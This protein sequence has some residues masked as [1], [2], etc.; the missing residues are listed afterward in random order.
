MD[1]QRIGLLGWSH[2]GGSVLATIAAAPKGNMGYAAAVAFY[3]DC[4]S[5]S[6]ALQKFR[7]YAPLLLL[8]GE[9]DDWTPAAPCKVL[10]AAVAARGEPMQI[11][12]YP[13]TFH[14]FDS[15]A[16]TGKRVRTEVPNGVHPGRGVTTA[17]N[18]EA[19]EDAKKRVIQFFADQLPTGAR[20]HLQ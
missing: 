4:T 20:G 17:P 13:D 5:K 11:V 14:N 16:I 1:A 2:G 12:T 18:Q 7:P 3:P 10:A 9:A 15:P 8:I 19:R 6:K